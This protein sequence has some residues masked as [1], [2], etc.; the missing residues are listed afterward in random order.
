V[1]HWAKKNLPSARWSHF[2]S[3]KSFGLRASLLATSLGFGIGTGRL[4]DRNF[5]GLRSLDKVLNV[6]GSGMFWAL[7]GSNF[8]FEKLFKSGQLLESGIYILYADD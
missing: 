3:N 1:I 7:Q 2:L 4:L 6:L 8:I 5:P